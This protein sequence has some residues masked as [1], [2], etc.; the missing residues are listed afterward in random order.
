MRI[1]VIVE[2]NLTPRQL[3]ELG[4]A[5]E[6]AG[7]RALWMSNY[8]GQWD[9][10]VSL[11]PLAIATTRLGVGVLAIS[12]F[13]MH[14]AKIATALL[15]LNHV[16]GGRA[17]VAIGAGE[18][19]VRALALQPP[20]K[21]VAAVREAIEI[22]VAARDGRL[23]THFVGESFRTAQPADMA[24]GRQVPGPLVY[25]T[26]YREQMMRMQGRVADGCFIGATPPEWIGAAAA[27]VREGVSR[28]ERPSAAFHV[29]AFWAWH[30]KADR[31]AAY[32]ESRRE[33]LTRARLLDA[34]LIG[35][36]LGP[37]DVALV[38][39]N[40]DAF[41][42]GYFDGSGV[43]GGVPERVLDRLCEAFTST[44]GIADVE[45]E[46]DR[47][48]AFERAGLSEL[49]LRLHEDPMEAIE[50]IG[51]YVVPRFEADC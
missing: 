16:A 7:I 31:Q 3:V 48:A 33:L 46:V 34:E 26:A 11:V 35:R 14:P 29:N 18:G 40:F 51:R 30:V 6:R 43:I 44:C 17:M 19:V 10:F 38:R 49:A 1:D 23:S 45:R 2:P 36:I 9:P 37:E 27:Q 15:S 13:E 12:P 4:I 22:V 28:R 41:V 50:Q 32:R 39:E 20:A 21:L 47:L 8:F 5:A 25:G 24:W 42:R